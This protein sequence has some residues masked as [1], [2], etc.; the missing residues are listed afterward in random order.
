MTAILGSRTTT[1]VRDDFALLEFDA[2]RV[3]GKTEREVIYALLGTKQLATQAHFIKVWPDV[4]SAH[5]LSKTELERGT[6]SA[7]LMPTEGER[8]RHGRILRAVRGTH[9][10]PKG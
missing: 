5:R 1:L 8:A 10:E 4:T 3:K 7:G 6:Q 2:I 9:K